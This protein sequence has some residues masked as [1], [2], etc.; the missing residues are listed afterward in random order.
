MNCLDCVGLQ[1]L[2]EAYNF[3][4]SA[5]PQLPGSPGMLSKGVMFMTK[6][7]RS[8]RVVVGQG[9][10]MYTGRNYLSFTL[11]CRLAIEQT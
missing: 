9:V 1:A 4:Q 7:I 11:L 6:D 2:D 10:L 5:T 3:G 8:G